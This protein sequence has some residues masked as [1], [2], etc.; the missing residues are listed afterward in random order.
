[1]TRFTPDQDRA[2]LAHAHAA[3][4]ARDRR[5]RALQRGTTAALAV[6]AIAIAAVA[7]WPAR[8]AV[9]PDATPR[10]TTARATPSTPDAGAVATA[11]SARG[12]SPTDFASLGIVVERTPPFDP[13]RD[14][15]PSWVEI[16]DGPEELEAAYAQA[17]RCVRA[18]EVGQ[19][20]VTLACGAETAD[21]EP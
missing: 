6:T 20:I 16:I 2:M 17:G 14:A 5:R 15:R 1:M 4:D 3:I 12:A 10:D 11:P 21:S 8:D 9:A 13:A 7:W 18:F 19:R